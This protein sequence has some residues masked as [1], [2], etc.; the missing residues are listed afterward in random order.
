MVTSFVFVL[1]EIPSILNTENIYAKTTIFNGAYLFDCTV[2]SQKMYFG[3]SII[4]I[5]TP[6]RFAYV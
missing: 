2:H 4:V 3:N 1:Q 6:T 5:I